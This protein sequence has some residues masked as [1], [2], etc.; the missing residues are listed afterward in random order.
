M[1][2][3]LS[4]SALLIFFR[5]LSLHDNPNLMGLSYFARA[6]A[7]QRNNHRKTQDKEK[8]TSHFSSFSSHFYYHVFRV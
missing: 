2:K 5:Q 1:T 6:Q 8:Q 3:M 4:N 7:D